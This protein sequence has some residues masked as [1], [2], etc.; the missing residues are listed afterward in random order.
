MRITHA[1][2]YDSWW[3]SA[4]EQAR[5]ILSDRSPAVLAAFEE[6]IRPL[7]TSDRFETTVVDSVLT[8]DELAR[9]RAEIA[10]LSRTELSLDDLDEARRFGRFM[11]RNL[12]QFSSLQRR[13]AALV[14]DLAGEP[15]EPT[16]NFLSMYGAPGVCEPHVDAPCAKWTLD[17]CI[18]Q[19]APWPLWISQVVPWPETG[20][21]PGKESPE[22]RFTAYTLQPG[23]AVLFSGSS[24]WHYRDPMP[25]G[26]GRRFCDLLFLHYVPAGTRDASRPQAWAQLFGE[27]AFEGLG[28]PMDDFI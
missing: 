27:A 12:P 11:R 17:I 4:H 28:G 2:W 18:D 10:G 1:S 8:T 21:A 24:Q 23:Q 3:L 19:S 25:P 16:Y 7:R 26:A 5:E 15:V 14:S 6:S 13:L 22:L 9:V 20:A